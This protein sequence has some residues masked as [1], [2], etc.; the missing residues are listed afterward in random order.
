MGRRRLPRARRHLSRGLRASA[1]TRQPCGP[2]GAAIPLARRQPTSSGSR[3]QGRRWGGRADRVAP[4][5]VGRCVDDASQRGRPRCRRRL[6]LSPLGGVDD[7]RLPHVCPVQLG[8]QGSRDSFRGGG[9]CPGPGNRGYQRS[10][11]V[12]ASGGKGTR[13]TGARPAG[14]GRSGGDVSG[15]PERRRSPPTGSAGRF[16]RRVSASGLRDLQGGLRPGGGGLPGVDAGPPRAAL[17][18]HNVP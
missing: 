18:V 9:C 17:C 6:R 2:H 13:R 14:S 7:G 3:G 4:G 10:A 1:A 11:T 5:T 12:I 8:A 15:Q 16:A